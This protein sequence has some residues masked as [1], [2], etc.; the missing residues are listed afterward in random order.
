MRLI[1]R[2]PPTEYYLH[3]PATLIS[4]PW[5][6]K[7]MMLQ[8]ASSLGENLVLTL[9]TELGLRPDP[10]HAVASLCEQ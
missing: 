4:P 5:C 3:Y 2:L 1:S 7:L 8:S 9:L 6:L 10:G